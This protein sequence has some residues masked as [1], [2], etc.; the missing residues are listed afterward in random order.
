MNIV[1]Y[2]SN[3]KTLNLN[4]EFAFKQTPWKLSWMTVYNFIYGYLR[5]VGKM[6]IGMDY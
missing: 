6:I 2:F 4:L 1:K 3:S 5:I